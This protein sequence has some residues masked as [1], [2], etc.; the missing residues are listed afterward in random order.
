MYRVPHSPRSASARQ[1]ASAN[2][3]A[4]TA[5]EDFLVPGGRPAK[6]EKTRADMDALRGLRELG[7]KV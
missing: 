5:L 2:L 3:I 7:Y 4:R 1:I 6:N